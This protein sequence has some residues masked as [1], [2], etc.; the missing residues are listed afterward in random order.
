[1]SDK[2]QHPLDLE[3]RFTRTINL[4][5]EQVAEAISQMR[6]DSVNRFVE[7]L[8]IHLAADGIHDEANNRT[9]LAERL[10][11]AAQFLAQAAGELDLAWEICKPKMEEVN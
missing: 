10:K 7:A 1:M 3:I 11:K 5:P 4:S 9:Q 8:G 6:Y 2:K